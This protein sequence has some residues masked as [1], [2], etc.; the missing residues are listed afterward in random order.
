M[1]LFTIIGNLKNGESGS[2]VVRCRQESAIGWHIWIACEVVE[3]RS[4]GQNG[5]CDVIEN[6][7][8]WRPIIVTTAIN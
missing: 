3:R 4:W 6:K 8:R 1:L 7:R 5:V 2:I